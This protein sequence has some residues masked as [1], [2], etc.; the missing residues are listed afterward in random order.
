MKSTLKPLQE[1]L[2]NYDVTRVCWTDPF[3]K[4]KSTLKNC[5]ALY[6]PK[7]PKYND[8]QVDAYDK[9][10]KWCRLI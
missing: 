2:K 1:F 8:N 10:S 7:N 5:Q 9:S 3:K 6:A 4:V